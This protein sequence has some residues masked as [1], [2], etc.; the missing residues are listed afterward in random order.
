LDLGFVGFLLE[1]D[2]AAVGVE[3]GDAVALRVLDPVAEHGR[4]VGSRWTRPEV[5][6]SPPP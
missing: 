1:A 2:D 6:H 4:A 3:L 5:L